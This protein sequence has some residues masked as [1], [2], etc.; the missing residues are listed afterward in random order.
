MQ[1]SGILSPSFISGFRLPIEFSPQLPQKKKLFLQNM[2]CKKK[3]NKF[4]D[5]KTQ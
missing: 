4:N 5:A 2:V 3:V 1:I